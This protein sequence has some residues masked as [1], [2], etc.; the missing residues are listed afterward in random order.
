M[1]GRVRLG[2]HPIW[3]WVFVTPVSARGSFA[4]SNI[5]KK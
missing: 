1:S 2:G 5:G 4:V 3:L